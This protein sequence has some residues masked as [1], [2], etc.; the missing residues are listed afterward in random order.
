[1]QDEQIIIQSVMWHGYTMCYRFKIQVHNV[2]LKENCHMIFGM[3]E[4]F[5]EKYENLGVC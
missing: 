3:V 5:L 1:M 2:H 4:S